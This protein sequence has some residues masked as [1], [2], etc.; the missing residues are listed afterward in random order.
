L[1][2]ATANIRILRQHTIHLLEHDTDAN[3]ITRYKKGHDNVW[4]GASIGIKEDFRNG[5]P[6][7]HDKKLKHGNNTFLIAVKVVQ[8]VE[9]FNL[10]TMLSNINGS[11]PLATCPHS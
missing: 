11:A 7:I 8:I 10:V 6:I 3:D 4:T 5:V 2:N 1:D 9:S